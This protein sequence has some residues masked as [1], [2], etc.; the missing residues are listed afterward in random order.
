MFG[1]HYYNK[2]IRN[3]IAVFGTL[4]NN[5]KIGRTGP[6]GTLVNQERVPIAYGPRQKYLE[7]VL[8]RPDLREDKV[9]I[10]LPRMAFEAEAPVY[11]AE[12]QLPKLNTA[13]AGNSVVW[14]PAPYR[15]PMNLSIMARNEEEALQIVEQIIPYFR[16]SLGVR[17]RPVDGQPDIVDDIKITLQSVSKEDNYEGEFTEKRVIIYTLSFDVLINIYGYIDPQDLSANAGGLI[18]KSI[19]RINEHTSITHEVNPSEANADDEFVI[20]I[21]ILEDLGYDQI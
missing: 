21:S 8:Q 14:V 19:I 2:T 17:I 5:I 3:T 18:K 16:P 13:L 20:D 12:R 10:K 6:N 4:F 11:D 9:A 1:K 7:R 15:I